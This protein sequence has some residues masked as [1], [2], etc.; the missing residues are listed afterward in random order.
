MWPCDSKRRT[1]F[2]HKGSTYNE[3]F[4]GRCAIGCFSTNRIHLR[5]SWSKTI[6]FHVVMVLMRLAGL[7]SESFPSRRPRVKAY[8]VEQL[9]RRLLYTSNIVAA[10]VARFCC[11][12]PPLSAV[13]YND[14][15]SPSNLYLVRVIAERGWKS[16][17]T[18]LPT[19]CGCG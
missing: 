10:T 13:I 19:G 12:L 18:P 17:G 14:V 15:E 7:C 1:R 9:L 3:S 5:R 6:S 4:S 2:E 16:G 8:F 11:R